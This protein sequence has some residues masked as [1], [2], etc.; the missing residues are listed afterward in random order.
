MEESDQIP[1]VR[2]L[3]RLLTDLDPEKTPSVYNTTRRI[4]A[5]APHAVQKYEQKQG[6]IPALRT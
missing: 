1:L 2:I 3:A 6:R 5:G 4:L